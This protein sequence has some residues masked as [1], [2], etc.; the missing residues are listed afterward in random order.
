MNGSLEWQSYKIFIMSGK[1]PSS[2][3]RSR[4]RLGHRIA[5][6]DASTG[7]LISLARQ[8][9][10]VTSAVLFSGA[11]GFGTPM[12]EGVSAARDQSARATSGERAPYSLSLLGSYRKSLEI[13]AEMKRACE[14]YGVPLPLARAVCMYE[15]GCN[16]R[17][18]S[19]EGARGYFQVMPSTFRLLKVPT[20]I[21]AGV[22]YLS[23]LLRDFGREDDALAAYNGG[24]GRLSSGRPLPIE[25]LQYVVGVGIYRTLLTYEDAAIRAEAS[26]L[27]LHR[28]APGEDWGVVSATTG[29]PVLELRLYNPYIATRPLRPGALIAYPTLSEGALLDPPQFAPGSVSHYVTRRGDN[30]LLLAFALGIDLEQ[31]RKDNTLWRVQ[32]PFEGVR[33]VV[34][35]GPPSLLQAASG[36]ELSAGSAGRGG[37]LVGT[38]LQEG[39]AGSAGR[40][41]TS[42]D[43]RAGAATRAPASH[44]MHKVRRGES[45]G[46][47]ALRYGVSERSIRLA[48]KLRRPYLMAGQ[49]LRIPLD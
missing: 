19:S 34:Q 32:V 12:D 4:A 47:I 44:L 20:N 43:G 29:V 31:F 6:G 46:R 48:N 26:K 35:A 36:S 16:D 49:I 22:K 9:V 15:S 17:L 27:S 5:P 10:L 13:E 1:A 14:S 42:A 38:L 18:V 24:P 21:E 30:Y 3:F 25:T 8:A 11:T 7:R 2:P 45:L 40:S 39:S 33:L 23:W 28:V 41:S 37:S